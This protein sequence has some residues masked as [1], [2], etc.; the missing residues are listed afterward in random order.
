M[1]EMKNKFPEERMLL[2][3]HFQVKGDYQCCRLK[4]IYTIKPEIGADWAE[5]QYQ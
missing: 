2:P 3:R 4:C 1:T 5:K